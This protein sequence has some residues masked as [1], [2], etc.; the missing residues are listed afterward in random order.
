MVKQN[1]RRLVRHSLLEVNGHYEVDLVKME[2]QIIEEKVKLLLFCNPHNPG[3]R[4]WTKEELLAIGRLCQKHQVT[5]VSDE[6]HQDLIFKPHTF[7]SFTV[8]DETF[9]EFTVTLTAATKTFNLAGIKNS[10]LFIPNEKLRQSFVSLQDKNHQG[11]INTFGYVGTAAAYQTGE[12]WLTALLDYLKENID[13]ALSFFR[14][15][16]PSVRVMEPEGTY[17]LWLDFS[18]YSLT[19][20]ELR[21]TLIHKGK[22]VLNPGIS[23]GPQGSQHMRLNLAC[24]KET[25]EEGL[26]RIKKAFN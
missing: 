6:I 4:V 8:A 24:S 16:L 1:E 17:L 9:K 2:Q 7:T 14:E 11:G 20:R 22:V 18:S 21:D 5:V 13:F 12:E 26:L 23:F 25:L 10:M 19:D 15:E 3:G